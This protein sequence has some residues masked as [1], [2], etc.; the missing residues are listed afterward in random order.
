MDL[1][2]NQ[3]LRLLQLDDERVLASTSIWLCTSCLMC[4]LRCPR[5]IDVAKVMDS[6]RQMVLRKGVDKVQLRKVPELRAYPQIALVA[7]SRKQTG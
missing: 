7:L 3:V 6:L 1:M 5:R 2:P 4:T